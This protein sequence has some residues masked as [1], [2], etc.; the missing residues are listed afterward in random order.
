MAER[1]E[2]ICDPV[3]L[4]A[5]LMPSIMKAMQDHHDHWLSVDPSKLKPGENV[6]VEL[7]K[8]REELGEVNPLVTVE[9]AS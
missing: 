9:Q 4:E 2:R 5:K 8:Q 1:I 7:A 3:K 6:Q